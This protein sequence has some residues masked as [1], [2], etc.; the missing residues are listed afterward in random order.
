M[1]TFR[2]QSFVLHPKFMSPECSCVEELGSTYLLVTI[3]LL[4]I[5]LI[6]GL[7]WAAENIYNSLFQCYNAY[8]SGQ[9]DEWRARMSSGQATF[10]VGSSSA[11]VSDVG[12]VGISDIQ[13]LPLRQRLVEGKISASKSL[14][15]N[16]HLYRLLVYE[17]CIICLL[18]IIGCF[19]LFWMF[20]GYVFRVHAKFWLRSVWVGRERKDMK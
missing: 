7:G 18:Y 12:S 17:L 19:V 14:I 13:R 16:S 15:E 10:R 5:R 11:S 6:L 9:V 1:P 20:T 3:S 8:Y 4:V 2:P